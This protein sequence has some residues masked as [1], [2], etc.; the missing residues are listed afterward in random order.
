[1]G[2]RFMRCLQEAAEDIDADV[3]GVLPSTSSTCP[4]STPVRTI[5]MMRSSSSLPAGTKLDLGIQQNRMLI[6][7]QRRQIVDL[8]SK[9]LEYGRKIMEQDR[10][11]H[12]YGRKIIHLENK[13]SSSYSNHVHSETSTAFFE[14]QSQAIGSSYR[15][16]GNQR[17]GTV[18]QTQI[19][20]EETHVV[21]HVAASAQKL[22]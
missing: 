10:L 19:A 16:G 8:K 9:L 14:R 17:R 2:P 3:V 5:G 22:N 11:L 20:D 1:M 21:F 13:M 7:N 15:R 6:N 12:E 4:M 18:Q